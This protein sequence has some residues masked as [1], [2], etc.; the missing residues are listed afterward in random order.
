[1]VS[2]K[3]LQIVIDAQNRTQAGFN[4]INKSLEEVS[5]NYQKL[6]SRMKTAGVVGT[7]AF[8]GLSLAAKGIV[9]AGA[10]FEQT[11]IAFETMLGSAEQGKKTLAELAA[12]ASRTPF[13]LPQLEEASKRLLAY[14]FSAEQLLPT[15][16]SLGDISAGVGM[17]KLPQLI[18]AFGQVK[19]ATYLTGAELR[20]FTEAGV[21]L[22]EMLAKQSG[23]SAS[24]IKEDMESGMKI[25][26]SEVETALRSLSGEGGKFFNLMDRQSQSLGGQ[27]SNLKDQISL[28]ARVI[29]VELL[30]YLKPVVDKLIEMT[31]GIREFVTENPKL[32]AAILGLTLLFAGLSALLLPIALAMPGLVMIF[33][34]L[35]VAF[36]FVATGPGLLIVATIAA[37]GFAIYKLMGIAKILQDDWGVIWLGI[38][39]IAADAANA[40]IDT[41]EGMVNF[42]IAGVNRAIEAINRVIKLAQ[43]V[44]GLGDKISTIKSIQSVDFGQIDTNAMAQ[45]YNA[46]KQYNSPAGPPI[47]I[48]GNT[49]LDEN[50]AE[51]MGDLIMSRLKLSNAL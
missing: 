28:T 37:I 6:T 42:I 36:A 4:S 49:L 22:L 47:I 25:P 12:F 30:P 51:K 41:A 48:T 7:A 13:E 50:A 39:T 19:A 38:K 17:D 31:S 27:W 21:P 35:G 14:G 43:K 24:Q 23:K 20:Q 46:S 34:A 5:G 2:E 8:A 11:Q 40:V 15:L 18:L 33:T 29:G 16:K 44:P 9:K 26:F 1:M 45:R 3:K 32:S 10:D